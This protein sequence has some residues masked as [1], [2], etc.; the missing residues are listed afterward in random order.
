MAEAGPTGRALVALETIQSSPG[1]TGERLAS[2]LGVSD[3]AARRYVGILREVGIP[4]ESVS[5]PYGGYSDRP[6]GPDPAA[7]V[8]HVRGARAGVAVLQGWHG[9]VED[10]HPAATALG[11]I[12]RVLPAAASVPAEAM[13]RVQAQNP[14]DAAAMPDPSVTATVVQ[15]CERREQLRLRYGIRER[16]MIVDPW[17]VVV[18]H[19]RWYLLGWSHTVDA[20]RVLRIDRVSDVAPTGEPAERPDDLDAVQ[21][22]E[23]HLAEGWTYSAE[24]SIDAPKKRRGS[25]AAFPRS[26]RPGACCEAVPMTRTGTPSSSRRSRHRS[27]SSTLEAKRPCAP[28]PSASPAPSRPWDH[29]RDDRRT[30][31]SQA[32]GRPGPPAPGARP[33]GSRVRPAARRRGARPRRAHVRLGTSVGNSR[34]RSASRRTGI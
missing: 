21:T 1:I 18:R 13:R 9:S 22:V 16:S 4:I 29:R 2:R 6:R 5:G 17:A 11:K 23:D 3:R 24:V 14:G 31:D 28:S 12:M 25:S 20:R 8:Q 10:D 15:A 19:G 7:D 33:D 34:A 30:P 26:T 27:R 32:P